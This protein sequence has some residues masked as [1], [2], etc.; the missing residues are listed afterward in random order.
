[1]PQI[2]WEQTCCHCIYGTQEHKRTNA[3]GKCSHRKP[4]IHFGGDGWICES[5]TRRWDTKEDLARG[6]EERDTV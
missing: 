3:K 6:R 2:N 4:N 1:M 5:F